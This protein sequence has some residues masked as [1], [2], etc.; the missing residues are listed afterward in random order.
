MPAWGVLRAVCVTVMCVTVAAP[1]VGCGDIRRPRPASPSPVSSARAA[2]E[3]AARCFGPGAAK[4]VLA[5]A[6]RV[7]LAAARLGSGGRG[8]VLVNGE[9]DDMCRWPLFARRWAAQGYHVLAF[10]LRCTGH[11]DCDRGID[12]VADVEAAVGALRGSGTTRVVLIGSSTGATTALV[13]GARLG[14]RIDGVVSLS[15]H[16]LTVRS[17]P[18]GDRPGTAQEAVRS[19]RAPL[20]MVHTE[21]DSRAMPTRHAAAF[22]AAAPGTDKELVVRPGT[23]HGCNLLNTG[24]EI[25]AIVDAFLARHTGRPV[26]P[27]G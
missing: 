4:V 15:A 6:D 19:F 21:R 5:T 2:P 26:D 22:V 13:A 3:P 10:D 9:G 20:L 17:A 1:V 16:S 18:G 8:L 25:P 11:S 7:T 24:G 14:E 12:H 27:P 23:A